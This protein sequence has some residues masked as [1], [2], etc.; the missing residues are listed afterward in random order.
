MFEHY[1]SFSAVLEIVGINPYVFLPDDILQII[2]T[3]AKKEKGAI[4][5]C[6]T[7]NGKNYQQTL[8]RYKGDWRLYIN[9]KMLENSPQ[10]IGEKIEVT[11]KFDS[12]DRMIHP[13][14]KLLKALN[15]NL[16]AREKFESL[17]PSLQKEIILYI[18][19]L[20]SDESIERNIAKAINFLEGKGRFIG[21]ENP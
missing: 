4:P 11:I 13:H 8:V 14:P 6:G 21:R 9:L 18:S 2:F 20:K 16:V 3:Q 5:V 10:R 1:K 19:R 17:R 12:S 7:I 15:E